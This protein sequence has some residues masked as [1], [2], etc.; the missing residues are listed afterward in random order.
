MVSLYRSQMEYKEVEIGETQDLA[1]DAD[2]E[3]SKQQTQWT[4]DVINSDV[5]VGWRLHG[6]PYIKNGKL[7]QKLTK[8]GNQYY[9]NIVNIKNKTVHNLNEAQSLYRVM[10]D[11][12]IRVFT[13]QPIQEN[14]E[15]AEG[16]KGTKDAEGGT[17]GAKGTKDAKGTKGAEGAEGGTEGAKGTKGTKGA[18]G[19]EGGTEG[20]EGAE[21]AEGAE[22]TEG[23]EGAEG[24]EGRTEGAKGTEDAEGVEGAKGAKGTKGV[25]GAES[26]EGTKG[27]EG[28]KHVQ[29]LQDQEVFTETTE[30]F[31][32]VIPVIQRI[33]RQEQ[34]MFEYWIQYMSLTFK[35]FSRLRQ[36]NHE[37][38]NA[39]LQNIDNISA[40]NG[41]NTEIPD[42]VKLAVEDLFKSV[43]KCLPGDYYEY[44]FALRHI[45]YPG[46]T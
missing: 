35:V 28:T 41:I 40:I 14:M 4:F 39:V 1:A 25:K 21:G 18:E 20:T 45:L 16:A 12:M 31:K 3:L 22:G 26:T 33:E 34:G 43:F 19:A 32:R 7:V 38:S 27:A 46:R 8:R 17:E 2:S 6:P 11:L 10:V 37:H 15:G 29:R 36:L 24:A 44:E 30:T 42:K 9:T 23:T 5:N 13:T